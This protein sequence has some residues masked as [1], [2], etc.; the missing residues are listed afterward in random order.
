MKVRGFDCLSPCVH[1]VDLERLADIR[2]AFL[3]HLSKHVA[4]G[5]THAIDLGKA[6]RVNLLV[7]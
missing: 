1:G 3:D 5:R 6:R 2:H 7:L 4:H